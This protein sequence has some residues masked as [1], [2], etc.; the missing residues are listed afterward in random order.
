MNALLI[1][2]TGQTDVQLITG[3]SRR[4]F[5]KKICAALHDELERRETDWSLG[6]APFA[7]DEHSGLRASGIVISDLHS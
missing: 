5:D 6:D 1:I 3:H 7:K 2:T 4:E